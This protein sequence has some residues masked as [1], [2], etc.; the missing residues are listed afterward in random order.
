MIFMI[1]EYRNIL[2]NWNVKYDIL[3]I[4]TLQ[5]MERNSSLSFT[6]LCL[7]VGSVC[8][9]ISMLTYHLIVIVIVII[10]ITFYHVNLLIVT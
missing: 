8:G 5:Q 9:G 6:I 3:L 1:I 10:I 7:I 4:G 2:I